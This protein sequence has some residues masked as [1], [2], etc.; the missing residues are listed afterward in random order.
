MIMLILQ[1]RKL[2]VISKYWDYH[3]NPG[4]SNCSTHKCSPELLVLFACLC[5]FRLDSP[6]TLQHS[7]KK[8]AILSVVVG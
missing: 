3:S 2:N 6:L 7:R 4:L 1:M 5:P 8:F